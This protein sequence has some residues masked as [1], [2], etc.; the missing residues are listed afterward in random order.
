MVELIIDALEVGAVSA[1]TL[2]EES[3]GDN[4]HIRGG[5]KSVH[6]VAKDE[7]SN[8]GS[9]HATA[10]AFEACLGAQRGKR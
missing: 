10:K 9:P 1:R 2:R 3:I 6:R 4:F 5:E 8:V 7:V